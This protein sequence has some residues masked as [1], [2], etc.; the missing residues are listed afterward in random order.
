MDERIQHGEPAR[1]AALHHQ[2]V[3]V[4]QTQHHHGLRAFHRILHIQR[5]PAVAQ[6]LTIGAPVARAAA[7]VDLQKSIAAAGEKQ[8]VQ[9]KAHRSLRSRPA[10][11]V[12]DQRGQP[13]SRALGISWGVVGAI[14]RGAVGGLPGDRLRLRRP[15][16]SS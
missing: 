8:P 1:A 4:R 12:D 3:R 10:M 16:R 13:L 11:H 7:V 14:H 9:A 15:A 6:R 5:T 2:F